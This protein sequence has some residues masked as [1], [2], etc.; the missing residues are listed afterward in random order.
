MCGLVL[1]F[2]NFF[3]SLNEAGLVPPIGALV[4]ASYS[5]VTNM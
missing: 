1:Q 2:Y 3:C 5:H 4:S